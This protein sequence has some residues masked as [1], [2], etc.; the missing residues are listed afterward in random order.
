VAVVNFIISSRLTNEA[1]DVLYSSEY[2]FSV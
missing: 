2:F 1:L